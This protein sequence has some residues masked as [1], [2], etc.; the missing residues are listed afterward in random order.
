MTQSWLGGMS[1]ISLV[2]EGKGERRGYWNKQHEQTDC[3]GRIVL[4]F[5]LTH[6]LYILLVKG[7]GKQ[8]GSTIA[9][10]EVASVQ[11]PM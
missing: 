3:Q 1:R 4:V 8:K 9:R 10:K 5:I 6:F 7:T 11:T 2:G